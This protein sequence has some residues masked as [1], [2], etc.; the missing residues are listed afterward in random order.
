MTLPRLL[1]AHQALAVPAGRM[2]LLTDQARDTPAALFQRSTWRCRLRLTL[3]RRH[4]GRASSD[5]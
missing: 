3:G 5:P 1:L 2:Q 4:A